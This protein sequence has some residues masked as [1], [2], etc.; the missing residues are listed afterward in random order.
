MTHHMLI[1]KTDPCKSKYIGFILL[2]R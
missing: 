2:K 1:L